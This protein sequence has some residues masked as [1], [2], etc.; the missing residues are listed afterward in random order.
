MPLNLHLALFIKPVDKR[1]IRVLFPVL[2]Y[3]GESLLLTWDLTRAIRGLCLEILR[4]V[5]GNGLGKLCDRR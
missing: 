2:S 1:L 5:R 3:M 4:S